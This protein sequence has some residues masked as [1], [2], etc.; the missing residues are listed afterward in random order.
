[1]IPYDDIEERCEDIALHPEDHKHLNDVD[2]MYRCCSRSH[3]SIDSLV[4]QLLDAHIAVHP[5]QP[6]LKKV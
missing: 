2:G 6:W 5:D 4:I 3:H 1:V